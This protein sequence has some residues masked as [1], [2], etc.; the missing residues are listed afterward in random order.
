M[1]G[2]QTRPNV[3]YIDCHDLGVFL[4]CYGQSCVR[5]PNIDRLA[6]QGA[7]F[8]QYIAAAPICMPSR[9]ATYTGR[10]PHSTGVTGQDPL[11]ED[12]RC[13][14]SR[15]L[16]GGYETFLCG[17][18]MVLNDPE[19]AGFQTIFRGKEP[20]ELAVDYLG[21]LSVR[22]DKPFFLSV[23][24][25]LVHR[26]FGERYEDGIP[27]RIEVP[28]YLPDHPAVRKDLA[29]LCKQVEI[30]DT[31]I[32]RILSALEETG[33][34]DS[35]IV[36][37]TTEHGPAIARAKHTLYDAGLKIAL[38]IR[39]PLGIEQ[40]VVADQL[41]SNIDLLPTLMDLCDL[42]IPETIHGRSF[43]GVLAGNP[44]GGRKAVFSEQT[45]GRRS[46]NW[47]YTPARSIRTT[48]YK[49]IHSF[50]RI[51]Y[52]VDNGWLTRFKN[53]TSP[54]ERAFSQPVPEGQLF[55]LDADPF[56][57]V[58]LS[59]RTKHKSVGDDLRLRL[60]GFLRNTE[61]PILSGKVPNKENMPDVPQWIEQSD[62]TFVLGT[63]DPIDTREI[64]FT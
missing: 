4:G 59:D 61:D 62:G 42:E 49:Y 27:A 8:T 24:F 29:T 23:S 30:L 46:G 56:E 63:N 5:T 13:V 17:N 34:R 60:F 20:E 9:A 39:H 45:W 36:V 52:Y 16:D 35:T 58:N 43:A 21:S 25:M 57:L 32:G 64:P 53:D 11:N 41:L 6:D 40:G 48:R 10:M 12:E 44:E 15:F 38:L 1:L 47:F 19:W 7:R 3:L 54:V 2:T 37:F 50:R 18:L 22:A 31:R 14:A 26:P 51:P 55:D 33:L 28:P